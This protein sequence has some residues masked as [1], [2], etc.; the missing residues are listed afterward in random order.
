MSGGVATPDSTANV[1]VDLSAIGTAFA[2]DALKEVVADVSSKVVSTVSDMPCAGCRRNLQRERPALH[3]RQRAGDG[4]DRPSSTS[5]QRWGL[6][7]FLTSQWIRGAIVF[8]I[9]V[10]GQVCRGS[11]SPCSWPRPF[12]GWPSGPRP[13]RL[14]LRHILTNESKLQPGFGALRNW[15]NDAC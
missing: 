13:A 10:S 7:P 4:A 12:A 2:H 11:C 9:A 15:L 6:D 8:A 1:V 5:F 3:L 14:A